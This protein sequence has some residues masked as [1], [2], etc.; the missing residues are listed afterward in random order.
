M[1]EK[2]GPPASLRPTKEAKRGAEGAGGQS[3]HNIKR[4]RSAAGQISREEAKSRHRSTGRERRTQE[5]R[6][7]QEEQQARPSVLYTYIRAKKPQ[8]FTISLKRHINILIY[9]YSK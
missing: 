2:G 3:G 9:N 7:R 5:S 6:S 4:D 8:P 1:P